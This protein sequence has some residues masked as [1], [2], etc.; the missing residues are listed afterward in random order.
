MNYSDATGLK[1]ADIVPADM[2]VATINA[3]GSGNASV[4][5]N[6]SSGNTIDVTANIKAGG[7]N[8]VTIDATGTVKANYSG[9]LTNT[10]A[11][12]SPN[13]PDP[14]GATST[15]TSPVTRKPVLVLVKEYSSNVIAGDAIA[16]KI[17][18]SNTGTGDAISTPV[19]D[20]LPAQIIN[21]VWTLSKTGTASF[22]G[23][24]SGIGNVNFT[25][26]IPAG[27]GN[28]IVINVSGTVLPSATG[29]FT[30]T[31]KASPVEPDVPQ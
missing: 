5:Q 10:A 19:S 4:T 1:I 15:V 27:T 20:I 16:Y 29:S 7:G 18:I 21:P 25:G 13:V 11:V 23:T 24:G 8:S 2:V 17:T 22:V 30:N 9:T 28:T 26:S 3:S 6:A 12:T 31:A 14:D